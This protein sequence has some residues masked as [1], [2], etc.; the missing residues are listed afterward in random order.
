[1]SS[2]LS[3]FSSRNCGSLRSSS[4]CSTTY[5]VR[6][7]LV[8]FVGSLRLQGLKVVKPPHL[9][10]KSLKLS[11]SSH[12]LDVSNSQTN[13]EVHE[14]NWHEHHEKT[15]NEKCRNGIWQFLLLLLYPNT[16]TI[17]WLYICAK[18]VYLSKH[19]WKCPHKWDWHIAEWQMPP[20][21]NRTELELFTKYIWG[22]Y[23]H[24]N[25]WKLKN[26]L[27]V[28]LFMIKKSQKSGFFM[29]N[30]HL[31]WRTITVLRHTG[32]IV[33]NYIHTKCNA[34]SKVGIADEHFVGWSTEH[35]H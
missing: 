2:I 16:L 32:I 33:P 34:Y 13:E 15:K 4:V 14:K 7:R 31:N 19:H 27:I 10:S 17:V 3:T 1:M 30:M 35:V 6:D 18:E 22:W 20:L 11:I 25:L 24:Q 8:P 28:S 29:R 9:H 21:H 23:T 12:W 26:I 5:R